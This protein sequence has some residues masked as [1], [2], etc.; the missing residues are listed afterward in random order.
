MPRFL[1][2]ILA[3]AVFSL[4][5]VSLDWI[6]TAAFSHPRLAGIARADSTCDVGGGDYNYDQ[7]SCTK[8]VSCSSL[9][10]LKV[11]YDQDFVRT[12]A[13]K[14]PNIDVA[15]ISGTS[16][17]V[18][19]KKVSGGTNCGY[20]IK[21]TK[22]NA[23]LNISTKGKTT[24][25]SCEMTIKAEIPAVANL[26]SYSSDDDDSDKD[27][28]KGDD[29][30]SGDTDIGIK[31]NQ[32]DVR[33]TGM[34][35]KIKVSTTSG[36]V[37]AQVT[38]SDV[39]LDSKTGS[40]HVRG[41]T[42]KASVTTQEGNLKIQYCKAPQDISSNSLSIGISKSNKGDANIEFPAGSQFKLNADA[43]LLKNKIGNCS[44]CNFKITGEV[45]GYLMINSYPLQQGKTDACLY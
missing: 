5:F 26:V 32:G 22:S 8:T 25:S 13:S 45:K 29:K 20:R 31:A 38:S 24:S 1:T 41:L 33:I 19:M 42:Q 14:G 11:D 17:I 40:L 10:R 9:D 3:I 30:D 39:N 6:K 35:G 7:S 37:F 16:C 12:D 36:D 27:K 4:G 34:K 15:A 18:T 28:D 21:F 2:Q 43:D 23:V 44:S